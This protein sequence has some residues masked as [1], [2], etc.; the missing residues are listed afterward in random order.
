MKHLLLVAVLGCVATGCRQE[1]AA[2]VVCKV[3]EGPIAECSITQTK[4][5]AEFEVCWDFK[6]TCQNNATLE[7]AKTC[8][9][10]GDGKTV[11][12]TTPTDKIKISGPC[13]TVK[14]AVVNNMTI[15]GDAAK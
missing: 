6:V 14:T 3:A 1:V 10:V 5:S 13:D 11:S 12:A 2:S 4:G 9:K 15:N 8:A 7:A